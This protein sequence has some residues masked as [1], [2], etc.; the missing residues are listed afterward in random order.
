MKEELLKGLTEEQ[1]AKAKKCKNTDELLK[2]A[3]EEGFTLNDEQ[4]AA[5]SGGVCSES[6]VA[7]TCPKCGTNFNGG[8]YRDSSSKNLGKFTCPNCGHTWKELV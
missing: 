5:V 8:V 4:L 6:T 2:L 7:V 3:K 1:I